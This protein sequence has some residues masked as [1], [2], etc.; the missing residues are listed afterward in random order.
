MQSGKRFVY[1]KAN[2]TEL[3]FFRAKQNQQ[4]SATLNDCSYTATVIS[5]ITSNCLM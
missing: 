2:S 5:Q 1:F 3:Q 4:M